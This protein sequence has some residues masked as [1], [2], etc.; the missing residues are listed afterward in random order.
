MI[1]RELRSCFCSFIH[2]LSL[3]SI[4]VNVLVCIP[5]SASDACTHTCKVN[6]SIDQLMIAHVHDKC[7]R[8]VLF[9]S[10]ISFLV[11]TILE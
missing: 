1:C 11:C 6:P 10:D 4:F 2:K 7:T 9:F 3:Y 8:H 5:V